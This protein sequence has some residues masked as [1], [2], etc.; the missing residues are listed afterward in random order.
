MIN[1]TDDFLLIND[2]TFN[3]YSLFKEIDQDN[4]NLY[5]N[6]H[7]INQTIVK[8]ISK[9]MKYKQRKYRIESKIRY[10]VIVF[11]KAIINNVSTFVKFDYLKIQKL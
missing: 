6:Q 9:Q 5:L 1:I 2:I 10:H 8:M 7:Q 11:K 3:F 4:V